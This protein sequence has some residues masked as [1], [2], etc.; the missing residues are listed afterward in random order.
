[1][2][3]PTAANGKLCAGGKPPFSL[4]SLVNTLP[5]RGPKTSAPAKEIAPPI[6]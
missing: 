2:K 3:A 4:S 1:M 6:V 5:I